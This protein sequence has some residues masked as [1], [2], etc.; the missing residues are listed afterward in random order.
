[1]RKVVIDPITRLEGHGKILLFLDET[2]ELRDAVLQVPELR[3]FERFCQGRRAE[4]MPQI[5]E[6]ICGVCPE[7]HH[8]AS[9]K[10]LEDASV[11]EVR[12]GDYRYDGPKPQSR[13]AA[14]VMIA[15]S[16]EAASRTIKSPTYPKVRDMVQ[17]IIQAK[18]SD[19]Q[20]DECDLTFRDLHALQKAIE[21]SLLAQFHNRIDYP[22]FNFEERPPSASGKVRPLRG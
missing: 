16:C 22:G 3:G 15:D 5:T 12:E 6:R 4:E 13:E 14:V 2:G 18:A 10:A 9:A 20:F 7:A 11:C 8:L 19:G 1:M 17:K 21:K